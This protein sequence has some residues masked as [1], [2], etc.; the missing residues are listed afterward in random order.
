MNCG[1]SHWQ[2][3]GST[4]ALHEKYASVK[5]WSWVGITVWINEPKCSVKNAFCGVKKTVQIRNA[6]FQMTRQNN[7]FKKLYCRKI[8]WKVK[9]PDIWHL[10]IWRSTGLCYFEDCPPHS[11]KIQSTITACT[12]TFLRIDNSGIF[13]DRVSSIRSVIVFRAL[14]DV[15]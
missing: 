15:W 6:E 1:P 2:T 9:C 14:L 12:Y 8:V 4:L 10:D 11:V 7:I 5:H 3:S 13:V